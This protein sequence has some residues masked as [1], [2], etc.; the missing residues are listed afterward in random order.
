MSESVGLTTF[1]RMAL[2]TALKNLFDA[3]HFS[4]C[5]IDNMLKVT[6]TVPNGRVY[7]S[8]RLLHCVDYK[9]MPPELLREL[10]NMVAE[11]FKGPLLEAPGMN[12]VFDERAN[13]PR[14]ING[15]VH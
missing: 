9:D 1:E 6:R 15:P 5:T 7:Q 13:R 14:V 11:I 3:G 10:P 12:L 8:L 2:Q 4:I